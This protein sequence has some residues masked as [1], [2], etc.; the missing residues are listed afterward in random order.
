M[1]RIDDSA[2]G[3]SHYAGRVRLASDGD[4]YIGLAQ[5]IEFDNCVSL[6]GKN[7]IF[8]FRAKTGYNVNIK[9]A[10]IEWTGAKDQINFGTFSKR[11]PINNWGSTNYTAG[12]FFRNTSLTVTAV[13]PSLIT[14]TNYAD[15]SLTGTVSNNCNNLIVL[16][17][18]ESVNSGANHYLQLSQVGLYKG[19]SVVEWE[20]RP[21]QEELALCQRYYEKS[22]DLNVKQGTTSA[23]GLVQ[24]IGATNGTIT[25]Q[26]HCY[27]KVT[28]RATPTVL[29]FDDVGNGGT[30]SPRCY[31]GTTNKVCSVIRSGDSG[32]IVHCTDTTSSNG[33]GFHFVSSCEI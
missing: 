19:T 29:I 28:K 22:Y 25:I 21:V 14:T 15:Y 30:G 17:W 5:A 6:R 23:N 2:V 11:D 13:S 7:V 9:A 8:Q 32:F 16:V 31:R 27:Y 33:I 12:N 10:I 26:S 3:N 18:V 1:E 20:P 4:D 24:N